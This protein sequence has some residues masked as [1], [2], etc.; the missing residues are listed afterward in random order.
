M[1]R[2]TAQNLTERLLVELVSFPDERTVLSHESTDIQSVLKTLKNELFV[3]L[4][5]EDIF[6]SSELSRLAEI[7]EENLERTPKG[8]T[9]VSLFG[10]IELIA[11]REVHK[12]LVLK[13]R[14]K[15]DDYYDLGNWLTAPDSLDFLEMFMRIEERFG[16]PPKSISAEGLENGSVGESVKHIWK[17]LVS[18]A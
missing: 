4:S 6:D 1:I 11:K 2:P 15:W 13:W 3:D 8:L 14:S 16:F 5:E 7:L 9:I 17:H 10:E 18:K 12:S